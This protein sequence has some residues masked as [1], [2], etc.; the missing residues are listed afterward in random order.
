[1]AGE[2][3]SNVGMIRLSTFNSNSADA[4]RKSIK[5]LQAQGA[6][7]FVMDVRNNGGGLFPA[8][9][10]V[11]RMY[12]NRGTIVFIADT[13]GVRDIYEA[14]GTAF[15]TEE[16]LVLV[17]NRGTASASEVMAGS[18][19]DNRRA[20]I[21]GETTYGK[22][23]IQTIVPLS[24]MSTSQPCSELLL[25]IGQTSS[26]PGLLTLLQMVQRWW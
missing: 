7:A 21:V 25:R 17:V 16:P 12:Q 20:K 15:A 10:E 9:V 24:G 18:L 13:E 23:L 14:D 3:T 4:V 19:S 6:K 5:E 2:G 22:G 1:M 11:T 26:E 8:G